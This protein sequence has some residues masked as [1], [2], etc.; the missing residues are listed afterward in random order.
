LAKRFLNGEYQPWSLEKTVSTLGAALAKAWKANIPVIR[1]SVAPESSFDAIILAGPRH[2]ALGALIQAEALL[3]SVQE[4]LCRIDHTP[5][6]IKLPK[7]TQG[8][9]FGNKGTLKKKWQSLGFYPEYIFFEQRNDG[10]I[11]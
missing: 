2:P 3:V 7:H 1:L 10:E 4:A 8:F 5:K 6:G 11:F 9:I